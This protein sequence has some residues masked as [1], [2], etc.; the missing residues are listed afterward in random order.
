MG[1][2]KNMF[3]EEEQ[4]ETLRFAEWCSENYDTHGNMYWK[5]KVP[6]GM[7]D[8]PRTLYG[9]MELW[10]LY[11]EMQIRI[12]KEKREDFLSLYKNVENGKGFNQ[13]MCGRHYDA[14]QMADLLMASVNAMYKFAYK[15]SD[16]NDFDRIL[17]WT[18]EQLG[19]RRMKRYYTDAV[20]E[21]KSELKLNDKSTL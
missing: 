9:S 10:V 17:E 20:Y 21:Y 13:S 7:E 5:K 12:E 18:V 1:K 11:G 2:Y 6:Q 19:T 15:G 3:I 8:T 14:E 4:R 16:K